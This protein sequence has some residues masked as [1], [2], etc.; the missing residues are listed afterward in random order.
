MFCQ[1]NQGKL[2]NVIHTDTNPSHTQAIMNNAMKKGEMNPVFKVDISLNLVQW[3]MQI[4]SMG[5]VDETSTQLH[6]E[7]TLCK[8]LDEL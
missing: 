4:H 2:H 6:L 1:T 5:F 8:Y 3:R 7:D